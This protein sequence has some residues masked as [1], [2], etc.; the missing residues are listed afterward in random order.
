MVR[1]IKTSEVD[2]I[3]LFWMDTICYDRKYVITIYEH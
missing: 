2:R 1:D 3:I